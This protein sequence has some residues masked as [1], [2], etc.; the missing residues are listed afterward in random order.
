MVQGGR[1]KKNRRFEKPF[2]AMVLEKEL[3]KA[4]NS[5]PRSSVL[6]AKFLEILRGPR[7][8]WICVLLHKLYPR[9]FPRHCWAVRR[10]R[11]L[12]QHRLGSNC[13]VAPGGRTE[14]EETGLKFFLISTTVFN[15]SLLKRTILLWRESLCVLGVR[16]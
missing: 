12:M 8:M 1:P 3:V 9:K 5:M 2:K 4:A 7:L 13:F 16:T 14:G 15:A 10:R 6:H 11:F